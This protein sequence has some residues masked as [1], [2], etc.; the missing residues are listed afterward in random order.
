MDAVGQKQTAGE[1]TFDAEAKDFADAL[2]R[3]GVRKGDTILVHSSYKSPGRVKDGPDG[4]IAGL[5]AAVG[6]EGTLVMPTL[7]QA[8]FFNSY[9]TWHLDKPSDVGYL[10]E[11]FRKLPGVCRSDHA[12]HSVAA[13]GRNAAF[14]TCEHGAYGPHPCPFGEYAFADSSPWLKMCALG[15]KIIFLGTTMA[16]NTM[17]HV[18]EARYVESLLAE[19]A[20]PARRDALRGELVTF[21]RF[22]GTDGIWPLYD[23][24][25]MQAELERRGLVR[26]TAC[27]K[28]AV[29]C[30]DMRE[31]CDAA[32]EILRAD[33]A[34]WCNKPTAAWVRRCRTPPNGVVTSA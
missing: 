26:R 4:V 1:P 6:K 12:T 20:D 29:L 16:A 2:A 31:S 11:Y 8:D 33:P 14:L 17:K 7:C 10:T 24:L 19:V 3:L 21:G 9:K 22:V 13:R 34:R 5:E 28:A 27:G 32:L 15:A 25:L 30:V 23:G 18:V